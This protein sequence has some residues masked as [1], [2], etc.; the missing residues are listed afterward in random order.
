MKGGFSCSQ[1]RGVVRDPYDRMEM[2]MEIRSTRDQSRYATVKI[3]N[4]CRSCADTQ[5]AFWRKPSFANEPM[6]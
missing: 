5:V 2:R 6:L 3:G 1:C 4:I